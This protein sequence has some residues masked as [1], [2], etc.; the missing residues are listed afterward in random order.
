M[1]C[2]AQHGLG[3]TLTCSC[4]FGENAHRLVL[5]SGKLRDFTI[6]FRA[7]NLQKIEIN[8][9]EIQDFSKFKMR[10][11]I[12]LN[13]FGMTKVN[14]ANKAVVLKPRARITR[15]HY[16][17]LSYCS[18]RTLTSAFTSFSLVYPNLKTL[19]LQG[20]KLEHFPSEYIT[21][22]LE[23][24]DLSSNSI[25]ILNRDTFGLDSGQLLNIKGV[26]FSHNPLTSFDVTI[27][28]DRLNILEMLNVSLPT[29][30]FKALNDHLVINAGPQG[31]HLDVSF[32][33]FDCDCLEALG[34]AEIEEASV[35][36]LH[37]PSNTALNPCF[38]CKEQSKTTIF[39][40]QSASK[41]KKF[42]ETN[43]C[44]SKVPTEGPAVTNSQIVV[45]AFVVCLNLI[46]FGVVMRKR[47][48]DK[49]EEKEGN[50]K[51]KKKK[52]K[53][54]QKKDLKNNPLVSKAKTHGIQKVKAND[55]GT[56]R[57]AGLQSKTEGMKKGTK[58]KG[59][60]KKGVQ[61]KGVKKKGV[62]KKG[63]KKKGANK[64]AK[65]AFE[66]DIADSVV[67]S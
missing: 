16:L 20:N 38:N 19:N 43:K 21:E 9:M 47:R 44:E 60:N 4:C 27:F 5:S 14:L 66:E 55:K 42:F 15:L 63:L 59:L 28:G 54:E 12:S 3:N 53:N 13:A 61:K 51:R 25:K 35:I 33:K 11:L 41:L 23:R 56:V 18:L 67:T 10:E 39:T 46:V 64:N 24:L 65:G 49:K 40:S 17:E 26:S 52:N 8:A 30:N 29:F 6:S 57:K 2:T 31:V 1:M 37:C 58:K 34:L 50:K 62:K 7:K 45:I 32:N 36:F 48:K 22:K